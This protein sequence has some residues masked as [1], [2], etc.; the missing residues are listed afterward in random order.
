MKAILIDTRYAVM[1]TYANLSENPRERY[2]ET[3][4]LLEADH[5]E[6]V[7]FIGDVDSEPDAI[8][9]GFV[10]DK[11]AYPTGKYLISNGDVKLSVAQAMELF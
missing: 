2:K 8:L 7:D 9:T 3:L 6:F 1:I 4:S 11:P 10:G 5:L